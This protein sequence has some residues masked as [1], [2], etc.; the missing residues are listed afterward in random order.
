MADEAI[1]AAVP[2]MVVMM[3]RDGTAS[4]EIFAMPAFAAMPAARKQALLAMDGLYFVGFGTHT[5][6]QPRG[7]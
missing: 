6:P 2:D 3:R 1:I 5:R 4:E 7:I